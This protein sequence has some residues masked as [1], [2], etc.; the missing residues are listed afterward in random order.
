MISVVIP[1]FNKPDLLRR[2]LA[3]LEADAASMP[4]RC[5]IVVVDDGSEGEATR[6]VIGEFSKRLPLVDASAPRNEGRARARNRGWRAARGRWILFLD[7]DIRLRCGALRAHLMAQE[8]EEAVWMGAVVTAPEI[9]DSIL[10]DYLDSRGTAKLRPGENPPARYLLTQNVSIPR[11]ALEA[12]DGFDEDFGAYGFEDME[13]GF[14]LEDQAGCA[15]RYLSESV[16]EHVHHHTLNEYLGKKRVCGESTLRRLV[17]L[18][19]DRVAEMQLDLLPGIGS[20]LPLGQALELSWR[21]GL[22]PA[23]RAIVRIWPRGWFEPV[24]FRALD[25]LVLAAYRDGLK[26]RLP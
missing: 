2:T 13:L 21:W 14:R 26:R 24:V 20:D 15:F 7:D 3:A 25:Y 6:A 16:G 10:F 23:V 12:I 19:P 22:A 18:H 9:V 1:T 8:S 5:E 17:Q 11:R 4:D